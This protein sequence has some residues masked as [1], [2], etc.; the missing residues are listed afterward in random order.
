MG[1]KQII[2]LGV[3]FFVL[4]YVQYFFAHKKIV[5]LKSSS[6]SSVERLIRQECLDEAVFSG[7][8]EWSK[9]LLL[10]ENRC[11]GD[12]QSVAR[13]SVASADRPYLYTVPSQEKKP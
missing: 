6:D 13:G 2:R 3:A 11:A 12:S 5:S 10:V 1:K 4:F 9:L 7:L 8:I